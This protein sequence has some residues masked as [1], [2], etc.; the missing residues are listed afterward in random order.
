MV[1]TLPLHHGCFVRRKA[2]AMKPLSFLVEHLFAVVS[3]FARFGVHRTLW[4][5]LGGPGTNWRREDDVG[6][7]KTTM[8]DEKD[9][10]EVFEVHQT[11]K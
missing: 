1:C 7:A 5:Q 11:C 8:M 4:F 6:T 10:A 2:V 3:F 9:S